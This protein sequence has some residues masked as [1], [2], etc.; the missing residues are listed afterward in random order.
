MKNSWQILTLLLAV[1][2]L[3]LVFKTTQTSNNVN[4][5]KEVTMNKEEVGLELIM[6]RS[7]VR[8]Y[9]SQKVET[10][11]IEK[12]L[13]AGMA[14]PTAGNKQPW[15]FVVISE[16]EIL[17]SIPP[18]IPGAHMA[19]KAQVAIAVC[20]LPNKALVPE[21][22]IQ[23]CSAVTENILLAA[24]AMG[25][26]AVWCGAY[27]NNEIDKVGKMQNLLSL[28]EDVYVLSVIVLGYPDSEP[29]IKDK[30]EP[31]KVHYNKY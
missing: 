3:V 8:S 10:D 15:E 12:L 17:D 22:W 30:W 29:V 16:R 28:P 27:P 11:K 21:Y 5:T 18:I 13:K 9:T 26:G 24:H 4:E 31:A 14:A 20:G 6:T 1:T 2:V 7:S 25:L 23:D 19:A